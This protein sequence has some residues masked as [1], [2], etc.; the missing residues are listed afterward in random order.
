M[1]NAGFVRVL[2][3]AFRD[4]FDVATIK[5]NFYRTMIDAIFR[6]F[7]GYIYLHFISVRT[8]FRD[9]DFKKV[10]WGTKNNS[11]SRPSTI[12]SI[13]IIRLLK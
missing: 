11:P 6:W 9:W 7:D 8:G 1:E 12:L 2:N 3:M 4:I 10:G 5:T 13:S